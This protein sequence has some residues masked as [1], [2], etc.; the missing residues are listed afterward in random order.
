MSAEFTQAIQDQGFPLANLIEVGCGFRIGEL[1]FVLAQRLS[2]NRWRHVNSEYSLVVDSKLQVRDGCVVVTR[3]VRNEATQ[4]SPPLD[5]IEPLYLE[6]RQPAQRWRHI[7]A[8]GGTTEHYYPPLAYRTQEWS[9]HQTGAYPGAPLTIE[10]HPEGRSSNLHLPLIISLVSPTSQSEGLFCGIEW[11]AGWYIRW[12]GLTESR[13]AICVGVKVRGLCL[14]AGESLD[15]PPVHLGFFCGGPAAGTNTLRRYLYTSVCARYQERPVLPL[16]SYDHWFGI[17]NRLSADLLAKQARRAAELGIETF[18]VDA[19]WFPGDF[20][21]GVGNWNA[22]DTRKFPD[23]LDPFAEY[24]R[25]LGMDFGLWFEPER[26]VEGTSWVRQ[27]PEWFVPVDWPSPMHKQQGKQHYHLD[28]SRREV[29]DFVIEQVS[30]WIS[31]LDIRWSRWDYNIE[32]A[33]FWLAVDSSLKVQFPY[34][35]GLYRVLDTLMQ[36]HPD[37]MVEGCSSGGRRIDIGMMKRAHTFWFSDQSDD[38]FL[39][40]YMQARANRFLPGHLLN[41]SVAVPL[42]AGDA[43]FDDVAI[44]S[45]MLGK[46]AFDGDIASWSQGL[47]RRMAE[48]VQVF[49]VYRHLMVQDFYQLQPIPTTVEDWDALQFAAYDGSEAI[50]F[51][52]AGSEADRRYIPLRGLEPAQQYRITRH[53]DGEAVTLSGNQL[54]QHGMPVE[55]KAFSA[56]FWSIRA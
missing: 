55:L 51:V 25:S 3:Q 19:S 28:L 47:T 49:K 23:G 12:I 44:L 10:S 17:E 30:Y 39:C 42:N 4:L 26:A 13:S 43:G 31:R 41:S 8:N 7:Y 24:V 34:T 22:V 54:M 35:A 11:S 5:I 1:P 9:R 16:V 56:G 18:V 33:P 15:L 37:W 46:L 40:R 14:A 2:T 53:L 50:L 52:F 20:P 45:R 6:F 48:W 36:R 27:H 38:P 29:Q 32:P 21:E